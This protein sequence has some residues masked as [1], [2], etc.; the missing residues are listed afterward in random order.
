MVNRARYISLL[1]CLLLT[2]NIAFAGDTIIS[3]AGII[4]SGIWYSKDPFYAGDKI[5]IYT[6]IFNGSDFDLIGEVYFEDNGKTICKGSFTATSGRSQEMWCDW[7][8]VMG[9]HKITAKILKPKVAPIGEIPYEIV[10][11]NNISGVSDK[12][13]ELAPPKVSATTVNVVEKEAGTTTNNVV[14]LATSTRS[15]LVEEKIKQE[16]N[17][18]KENIRE[19]ATG[20]ISRESID[21]TKDNILSY[22]PVSVVDG[23]TKI[24]EKTGLDRLKNPFSYIVDFFIAIYK[25]VINDPLLLV[26]IAFLIIWKLFKYAYYKFTKS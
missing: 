20:E 25:F 21:K 23:V 22:I 11:E 12:V 5:R 3:N 8:A 16:L 17:L 9:E 26:I 18:F 14:G 4:R 15:N 6:I 19:I 7:E 1:I 24:A 10:L 2:S 13:V